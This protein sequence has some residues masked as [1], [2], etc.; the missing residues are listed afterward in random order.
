[1][2]AAAIASKVGIACPGT[3][4]L[5]VGL[6]GGGGPLLTLGTGTERMVTVTF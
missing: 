1:M 2:S 6:N 4:A 5:S 3:P